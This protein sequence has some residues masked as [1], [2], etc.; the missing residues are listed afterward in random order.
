MLASRV[1]RTGEYAGY[2]EPEYDGWARRSQ[3]V[4]VRDGT[5]FAVD[6]F[7]PTS[8]GKEETKALPVAWTAKR[9]IRANVVKGEV[10]PSFE[11]I[12]LHGAVSRKLLA[13]GYVLAFADMRGTGASFGVRGECSD[14]MD[15]QDGYDLNE[16]LAVQPFCDGR[17]GM[18]G[19]S[20]E[21]RTQ[22]NTASVAPPHLRAIV[23]EV[24]PFDWYH[25]V[26]QGGVNRFGVIGQHFPATDAVQNVAPVDDD[27]D[28]AL[29]AEA[30]RTHKEGND[31]TAMIGGLPHRDSAQAGEQPWIERSGG[32]LVGGIARSGIATYHRVGWFANVRLEQLLWFSNLARLEN[33][34]RHRI[35]V[36]PWPAGGVNPEHYE[37]WATETLRFL[38]YWVK[39]IDNGIMDEPAVVYTT[40]ASTRDRTIDDWQYA[41]EW[42]LPEAKGTDFFFGPG[43]SGSVGSVNDGTLLQREVAAKSGKDDYTIVYGIVSPQGDGDPRNAKPGEDFTPFE[44]KCL[45]YTSPPLG[46]DL[47]VTG[48]PLLHLF[49]SCSADDADFFASVT[50]V[51][52]KGVSTFVTRHMLRASNRAVAPAPYYFCDLPWHRGYA[53]DDAPI[54]PGEIV[55]LSFDLLPTSYRFRAGHRIRVSISCADTAFGPSGAVDPAPVVSLW[56]DDLHRSRLTLPVIA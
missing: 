33:G 22:L 45:T 40:N 39:E 53:K 34:N 52:E 26:W 35:M 49:V 44:E 3:Y 17:V 1:S 31:Y 32:A 15:S 9:Y 36:G 30:L 37:M 46:K 20:Y 11:S 27:T 43:E 6:I 42:P 16:W 7:T 41:R 47:V 50:D 13:H 54:P 56:R 2:S 29:L 12:G 4:S 8:K 38:D 24:S 19:V 21:G 28:G 14:P 55:E 25:I 23:P 10:V 51:D 18:F 5:R 48:H